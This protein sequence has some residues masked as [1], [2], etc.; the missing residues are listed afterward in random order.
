[1]LAGVKRQK[2]DPEIKAI[3]AAAG[4]PVYLLSLSRINHNC[5]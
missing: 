2:G 1:V 4:S 5:E 3:P